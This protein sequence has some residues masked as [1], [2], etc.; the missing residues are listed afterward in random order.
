MG[1]RLF[2]ILF[3]CSGN[4][5]RSPMAE[6]MLR[7]KLPDELLAKVDIKSAGTMGLYGNS[8]TP[9]AIFAAREK[10]ADISVH[11]S[12]GVNRDII[13][14]SNI[15]FCMAQ[16]HVDFIAE[17]FPEAEQKV[18]LLKAFDTA[19]P[20]MLSNQDIDDPIGGSI[21]IYRNCADEIDIELERILPR[22]IELI[23]DYTNN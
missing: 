2:T 9:S 18:Y 5:C 11:S 6:G 16:E 20:A 1:N 19:N 23:E 4:S 17:Y 7:A 12:Q 21:D 3:V 13:S 15:I 22:I 8:A 10:G 14:E